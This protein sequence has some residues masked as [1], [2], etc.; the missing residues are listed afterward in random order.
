M[1]HGAWAR[2][3]WREAGRR[4]RTRGVK[5]SDHAGR[6]WYVATW[7]VAIARVMSSS[8]PRWQAVDGTGEGG[9][10][11]DAWVLMQRTGRWHCLLGFEAAPRNT[12]ARSSE[13]VRPVRQSKRVR[14]AGAAALHEGQAAWL[15]CVW[16]KARQ[17]KAF[18]TGP[19]YGAVSRKISCLVWIIIGRQ[20]AKAVCVRCACGVRAMCGQGGHRQKPGDGCAMSHQEI[21][22]VRQK[23]IPQSAAVCGL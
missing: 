12:T 6:G 11:A 9:V 17:Q 8:F 2:R 21:S 3:M 20:T 23:R 15:V 10:G 1:G 18:H 22:I 14:K 13:V 16:Q 5:G 7:H 19:S 4:A